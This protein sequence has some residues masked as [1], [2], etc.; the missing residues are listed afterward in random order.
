MPIFLRFKDT[1]DSKVSEGLSERQEPR[2]GLCDPRACLVQAGRYSPP[3]GCAWREL[4]TQSELE[5]HNP[6]ICRGWAANL[7]QPQDKRGMLYLCCRG[8]FNCL[9]IYA[10]EWGSRNQSP[11]YPILAADLTVLRGGGL[12]VSQFTFHKQP[13]TGLSQLSVLRVRFKA[14]VLP[15]GAEVCLLKG[16]TDRKY[17]TFSRKFR[18]LEGQH[19]KLVSFPAISFPGIREAKYQLSR[20]ICCRFTGQLC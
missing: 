3:Q 13:N 12:Y 6:N 15:P 17:Q 9:Q 5:N 2:P 1:R 10:N 16:R 18:R 8:Q 20:A 14:A 4:L 19:T 11:I 7:N